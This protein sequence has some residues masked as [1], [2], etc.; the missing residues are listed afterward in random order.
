MAVGFATD[1][2]TLYVLIWASNRA[3]LQKRKNMMGTQLRNIE[4]LMQRGYDFAEQ[5]KDCGLWA[6]SCA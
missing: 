1:K 2:Q 5:N 3:I 4:R 6:R